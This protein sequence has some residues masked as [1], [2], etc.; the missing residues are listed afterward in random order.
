M[1][2]LRLEP[3]VLLELGASTLDVTTRAL[4]MGVL[5]RTTDSFYAPAATF[6]LDALLCRADRLVA[7]GADLLDVGGVRAGPGPEVTESEELDRVVPVVDA[8]HARFDVPISIDTWRAASPRPASPRAR[9]SATT[10]RGSR[11]PAT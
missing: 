11:T 5:N 10:S 3:P 1:R 6:D 4:V 7:D 9:S 2:P 8:L